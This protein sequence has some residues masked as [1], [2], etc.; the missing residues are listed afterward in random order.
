MIPGDCGTYNLT[1][2]W[3]YIFELVEI[4]F[5]ARIDFVKLRNTYNILISDRN[6]YTF[7]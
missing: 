5:D 1:D 6:Q 3:N 4:P 7:Y 2:E